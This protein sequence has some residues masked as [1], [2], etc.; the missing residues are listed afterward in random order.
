MREFGTRPGQLSI[1]FGDSTKFEARPRML[2]CVSLMYCA[3]GSDC[4]LLTNNNKKAN[5][6]P[7]IV[8]SFLTTS[9]ADVAVGASE[10]IGLLIPRS[11]LIRWTGI[12]ARYVHSTTQRTC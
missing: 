1:G 12:C 8:A 4:L 6:I 7:S 5:P 2:D 9:A 3:N 11:A 10:L